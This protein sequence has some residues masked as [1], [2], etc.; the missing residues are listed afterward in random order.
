[1][2]KSHLA[3]AER[4]ARLMIAACMAYL[5][6]VYFGITAIKSGIDNQIHRT[7]RC[8]WSIFRMGLA[9]FDHCLNRLLPLPVS[10]CLLNFKTVR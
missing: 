9:F 7:D 10:C 1:L 3:E 4:L 6:M 5:W 8:D 2:H